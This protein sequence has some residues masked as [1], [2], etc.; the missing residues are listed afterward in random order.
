MTTLC[1]PGGSVTYRGAIQ[2]QEE[3]RTRFQS[4]DEGP[5][6][7]SSRTRWQQ[8]QQQQLP[9]PRNNQRQP[10]LRFPVP[11]AGGGADPEQEVRQYRQGVTPAL[12][13]PG[14]TAPHQRGEGSLTFFCANILIL[15]RTTSM[16]L[17]GGRAEG[18]RCVWGGEEGGAA[19]RG[20]EEIERDPRGGNTPGN[21]P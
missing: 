3:G 21:G 9:K 6:R 15:F 7:G 20:G 1:R 2:G 18:R 17:Q 16:P 10:A 4:P 8:Q 12:R 5:Y 19:G 14:T 13:C 11:R